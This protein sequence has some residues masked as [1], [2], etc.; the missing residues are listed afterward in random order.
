MDISI[1]WTGE[2]PRSRRPKSTSSQCLQLEH[3][4]KVSG[5]QYPGDVTSQAGLYSSSYSHIASEIAD[6]Y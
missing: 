6:L 5:C 3:Q 1:S 4:D 2:F